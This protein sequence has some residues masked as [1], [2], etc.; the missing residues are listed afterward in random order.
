[1]GWTAFTEFTPVEHPLVRTHPV[2]GKKSLFVN[3]EFTSHIKG[4]PAGRATDLGVALRAHDPTEVPRPLQLER[5]D[6]GFWDNRS[7]MHFVVIDYGTQHRLIQRVTL[8][9][10][11]PF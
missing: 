7:T 6:L 1:M 3:P 4:S 8:R 11:R 5:R 10:E 2:S 9:G